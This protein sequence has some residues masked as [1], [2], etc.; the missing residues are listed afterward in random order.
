MQV[1]A[2]IRKWKLEKLSCY[3]GCNDLYDNL[4][5]ASKMGRYL[6]TFDQSADKL[7][8]IIWSCILPIC[9]MSENVSEAKL[10]TFGTFVKI[11]C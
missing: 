1:A 10:K 9:K 11:T 3:D 2:D 5:D 7:K 8:E 6:Q 4:D